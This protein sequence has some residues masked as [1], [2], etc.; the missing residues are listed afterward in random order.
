[1]VRKGVDVWRDILVIVQ[2]VSLGR[3]CEQLALSQELL[4]PW[5]VLE[6]QKLPQKPVA[7]RPKVVAGNLYLPLT[8]VAVEFAP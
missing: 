3:P 7:Q 6:A 8:E 1:M 5:H 2:I 4:R